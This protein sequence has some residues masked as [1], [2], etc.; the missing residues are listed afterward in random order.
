MQHW[1]LGGSCVGRSIWGDLISFGRWLLW[2]ES[3]EP[4]ARPGRRGK[5]VPTFRPEVANCVLG[6]LESSKSQVSQVPRVK[7]FLQVETLTSQKPPKQA[8]ISK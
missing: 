7:D 5:F 2:G 3:Q 4:A 1:A 8:L 6:F